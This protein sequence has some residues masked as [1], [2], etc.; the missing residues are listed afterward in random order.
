M[1]ILD[2]SQRED[3]VRY[4]DQFARAVCGFALPLVKKC[5]PSPSSC[6]NAFNRR[7]R[8]RHVD[9]RTSPLRLEKQLVALHP[10]LR[11]EP[12]AYVTTPSSPEA[13]QPRT[14]SD[15]ASHERRSTLRRTY[16][17]RSEPWTQIGHLQFMKRREECLQ[18]A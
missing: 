17:P 8:Q 6:P 12:Q 2:L 11:L 9:D 4:F 1:G 14:R 13:S 16:S 7:R 3:R 15:A 5:S 18:G 10:Q